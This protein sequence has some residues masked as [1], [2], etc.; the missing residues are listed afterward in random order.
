[1]TVVLVNSDRDD[2]S[3]EKNARTARP[4][5]SALAE[6]LAEVVAQDEESLCHCHI[7]DSSNHSLSF[8]IFDSKDKTDRLLKPRAL[9]LKSLSPEPGALKPF[10]ERL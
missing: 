10:A 1:M 6:V 7:H 2:G 5:K 3:K 4:G 9:H 8:C